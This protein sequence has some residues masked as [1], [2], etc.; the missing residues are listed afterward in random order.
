MNRGRTT[1]SPHPWAGR[2]AHVTGPCDWTR[3]R[4]AGPSLALR[5]ILALPFAPRTL[6][7]PTSREH[8]KGYLRPPSAR[9]VL[10]CL[11]TWN[12]H[13]PGRDSVT[14]HER[15]SGCLWWIELRMTRLPNMYDSCCPVVGRRGTPSHHGQAKHHV[16]W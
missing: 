12:H 16:S 4:T 15:K 6:S 10:I 8:R 5:H 1:G 9:D 13:E 14:G 3:D 11:G 2:G 7:L